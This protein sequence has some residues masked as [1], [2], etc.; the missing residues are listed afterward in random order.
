MTTPHAHQNHTMLT[1]DQA[2]YFAMYGDHPIPCP[3]TPRKMVRF[4]MVDSGDAE[5]FTR[6]YVCGC[7]FT[8]ADADTIWQHAT[9]C[10]MSGCA[11]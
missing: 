10:T 1:V 7:T 4:E 6:S 5:N 2:F 11:A 9:R 3:A 8:T